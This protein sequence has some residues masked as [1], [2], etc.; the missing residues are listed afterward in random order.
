MTCTRPS[1]HTHNF[2]NRLITLLVK[3]K[4]VRKMDEGVKKS[5]IW[6]N[7]LEMTQFTNYKCLKRP[8]IFT[9]FIL[10]AIEFS[11]YFFKWIFRKISLYLGTR[12][13]SI[14]WKT[15]ELRYFCRCLAG[16]GS[17]FSFLFWNSLGFCIKI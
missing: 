2:P 9:A 3:S 15:P 11:L 1:F 17:N 16:G 8:K 12:N 10:S 5:K 13:E 6:P 4:G 14:A 7:V